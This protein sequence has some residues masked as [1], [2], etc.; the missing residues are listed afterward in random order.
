MEDEPSVSRDSA[1]LGTLRTLLLAIVFIGIL[2]TG[3]ELVLLGHV[4]DWVQL[5][6]ILLLVVGVV[7]TIWQVATPSAAS[8]RVLQLVMVLFVASGLV[9]I[10]YHYAGNEEFERELYPGVE[11]L[12]LVGESLAGATPVL[13][14]GAMM[15]LG[16]VGLT[17][18][19]R[20]P[21]LSGRGV[22]M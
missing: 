4:E 8:V 18:A 11:G 21:H 1:P 6:P 9:G 17:Y 3:V 19:H 15:L 2:G 5:S 7:V 14:P 13:A 22:G 10:G 12:T 16:L 20:H